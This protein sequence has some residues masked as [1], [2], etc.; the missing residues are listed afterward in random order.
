[1]AVKAINDSASLDRLAPILLVFLFKIYYLVN[2]YFFSKFW[3]S[4][5]YIITV[6]VSKED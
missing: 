3:D 4:E 5:T 1:M 2:Y 6:I